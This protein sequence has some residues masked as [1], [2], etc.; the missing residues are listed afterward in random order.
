[1]R[2]FLLAVFLVSPALAQQ[3]Q[4]APVGTPQYAVDIGT[5]QSLTVPNAARIAEICIE[6]AV[7]RYTTSG[8]T[9]TSS[10]G[11][12]VAIGG[13]F[14]LAGADALRAFQILG[15]GATMD[16]EYLQ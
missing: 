14:Q 5:V 9:P 13:C 1:M 15:S 12:P 10:V 7:A 4:Y 11:V 6:T 8:T 3:Y 16:V 2:A